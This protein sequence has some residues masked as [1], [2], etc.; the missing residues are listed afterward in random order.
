MARDTRARILD[1]AARLFHRNGF[2]ATAI[3]S[4]LREAGVNSGSLY[5]FFDNKE[6]LVEAVVEEYLERLEPEL[7]DVVEKQTA[8][9]LDRV[10][11]LI[12]SYGPGLARGEGGGGHPVGKLGAELASDYPRVARI[13]D[14]YFNRIVGGIRTWLDAAGSRLPGFVDRTALAELIVTTLEG[15]AHRSRIAGHAGPFDR[16]AE[17]LFN[18]LAILE[19]QAKRE[20]LLGEEARLEPELPE[21]IAEVQ[22]SDRTAWRSW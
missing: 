11:A 13:A 4:V 3:S 16:A 12:R 21:E 10:A 8:D 6:A 5:Y 1:S 17:Q 14:R 19:H 7:L 9:P 18:Y 2:A 20:R 22:R 15:G